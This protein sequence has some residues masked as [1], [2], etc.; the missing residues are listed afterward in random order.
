MTRCVWTIAALAAVTVACGGGSAT[1]PT[2]PGGAPAVPTVGPCTDA[3]N[4]PPGSNIGMFF[5]VNASEGNNGPGTF[6]LTFFGQTFTGSGQ[7][8]INFAG[9]T[10]GDYEVTGQVQ[11]MRLIIHIIR[12]AS[13]VPGGVTPGSVQAIEG[14]VQEVQDCGLSYFIQSGA[15]K[16]QAYRFKFTVTAARGN[17]C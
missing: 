15:P 12:Q 3:Q 6:S 5:R 10:A 16:P 14:P 1:S 9:L 17:N 13:N 8:D 2:S 11:S 4:C 7:K